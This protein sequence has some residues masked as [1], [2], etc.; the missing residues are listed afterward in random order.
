MT[1]VPGDESITRMVIIES[2]R[3]KTKDCQN[4]HF[5]YYLRYR[6]SNQIIIYIDCNRL[7]V[8]FIKI[9]LK[10]VYR[11]FKQGGKISPR[12]PAARNAGP[13]LQ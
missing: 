12:S 10:Y 3:D 9:T 8:L 6:D 13:V 2:K 4:A 5:F 7:K 11:P 1:S